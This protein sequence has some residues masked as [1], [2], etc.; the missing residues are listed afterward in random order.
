M[1]TFVGGTGTQGSFVAENH[2]PVGTFSYEIILT[3]TDS[4]GLTA[5]TSVFV[6]VAADTAAPG[7]PGSLTAVAGAAGQINLGW[8]AATDNAAVSGYRVER[9]LGAGCSNFAEVATPVTTSF[10]DSG[11]ASG[12]SYSYR[13][14]AADASGNLGGYSNVATVTTVT[15]S[16]TTSTP[17]PAL[18]RCG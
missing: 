13:V 6:G 5:S 2:G 7:T 3:A 18:G 9:C 12:T 4:S 10:A 16:V 14:R 15:T 17:P 11:L 8:T 1:H